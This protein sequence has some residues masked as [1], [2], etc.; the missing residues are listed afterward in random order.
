M[1]HERLSDGFLGVSQVKQICPAGASCAEDGDRKW[2]YNKWL[3]LRSVLVPDAAGGIPS[4]AVH[5]EA[6]EGNEE[7]KKPIR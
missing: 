5:Q 2:T 6:H 7:R 4:T 3:C 1:V